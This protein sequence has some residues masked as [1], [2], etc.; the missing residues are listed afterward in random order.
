MN[1]LQRIDI[2]NLS[3]EMKNITVVGLIVGRNEPKYMK[4]TLKQDNVDLVQR[5]VVSIT[6][7]D[8]SSSSINCAL[9]GSARY[10]QQFVAKYSVD[11]VVSI[12]YVT[13]SVL[14]SERFLPT[15]SSPFL[16][17]ATEGRSQFQLLDVEPTSRRLQQLRRTP[18]KPL[19]LCLNLADVA[20]T[21][22]RACDELV[23]VL[24]IVR[25]MK[26]IREIRLKNGS[27]TKRMRELVVMDK[28]HRGVLVTLWNEEHIMRSESW[29]AL[30]SVIHLI[31]VKIGYSTFYRAAYL[32]ANAKTLIMDHLNVDAVWQL[33]EYVISTSNLR[34]EVLFQTPSLGWRSNID[35]DPSSIR[36]VLSCQNIVDRMTRAGDGGGDED[37]FTAVAYGVITKFNVDDNEKHVIKTKW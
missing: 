18:L 21:G 25:Q 17:T 12:S 19:Q 6:I 34:D 30:E 9:W 35:V 36:T 10:I 37:M 32:I 7:R 1:V 14:A 4:S 2:K 11:N 27:G 31:D 29:L 22:S 8:C 15:T 13:V 3:P 26:P 33:R 5:G 20:Q 24:G 28:S 16:I 23:D